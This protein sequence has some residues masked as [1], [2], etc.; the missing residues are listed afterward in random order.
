M[1]CRSWLRSDQWIGVCIVDHINSLL[2]FLRYLRQR[3]SSGI[4]YQNLAVTPCGN[5]THDIATDG[6]REDTCTKH[7]IVSHDSHK[8]KAAAVIKRSAEISTLTCTKWRAP[9]TCHT[10]TPIIHRGW[11]FGPHKRGTLYGLWYQLLSFIDF[12]NVDHIKEVLHMVHITNL[13]H[14]LYWFLHSSVIQLQLWPSVYH[15]W[16]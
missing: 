9:F 2:I 6:A 8:A 10:A 5:G 11:Q 13:N 14:S 1:H 4:R 7:I 12:G 16:W 3:L 15:I